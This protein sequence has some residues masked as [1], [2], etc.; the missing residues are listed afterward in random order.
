[1]ARSDRAKIFSSFSPLNGLERALREKEK[2]IMQKKETAEDRQSEIDYKLRRIRVGDFVDVTYYK[3]GH[4]EK[5]RG[6][7]SGFSGD[8]CCFTVIEPIAFD[9]IYDIEIPRLEI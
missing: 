4:Y 6:I 1:M 2:I 8:K 9:D 7:V 5:L 3:N